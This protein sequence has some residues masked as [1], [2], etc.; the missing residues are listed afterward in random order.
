[1]RSQG[2]GGNWLIAHPR[3]KACPSNESSR[4]MSAET[5][6]I[7][8]VFRAEYYSILDSL[9][10][11]GS[12]SV[13]LARTRGRV[14]TYLDRLIEVSD[15]ELTHSLT[16]ELTNLQHR[17][18]WEDGEYELI[19]RNIL[20]IDNDIRLLE[21]SVTALSNHGTPPS[22]R[23]VYNGRRGRPRFEIDEQFL[24]FAYQSRSITSIA[25]L[26]GVHRCTVRQ[27]LLTYGLT[28]PLRSPFPNGPP[29][30]D[31]G[32]VSYTR[33]LSA[34]SESELDDEIRRVREEEGFKRAGVTILRG[35]LFST[36]LRVSRERIWRSLQRVDPENRIFYAPP[37]RRRSYTVPGPNSIWHHDGQHS[38]F[39][40][41]L[42][43]VREH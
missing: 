35:L 30:D 15:Q 19:L 1:M 29:G 14:D 36:G 31:N 8:H 32:L 22:I 17:D 3:H 4:S 24:R 13:I 43:Y 38:E 6:C 40:I 42:R 34:I 12:D 7:T 11:I 41:I 23:T 21:Q 33:P 28:A 20:L 18:I 16:E 25:N 5:P 39:F 26:L 9:T 10:D 27:A 2:G 37:I